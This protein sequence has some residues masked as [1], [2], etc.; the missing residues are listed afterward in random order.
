MSSLR[1]EILREGM[2]D[3]EYFW[4]LSNLISSVSAKKGKSE[5]IEKAKVLL[6]IP[7]NVTGSL[8]NFAKSPEP[9]F[10]HRAKIADMI[11][12]LQKE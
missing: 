11:E 6:V 10:E 4:L 7:E 3:Y 9:I 2:E 8:T 1:W 5:L 12:Q